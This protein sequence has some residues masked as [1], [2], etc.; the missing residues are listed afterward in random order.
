MIRYLF[1]ISL[2]KIIFI[3]YMVRILRTIIY[4]MSTVANPGIHFTRDINKIIKYNDKIN[5]FILYFYYN[6]VNTIKKQKLYHNIC[7]IKNIFI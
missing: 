7:I 2:A 3:I 5:F 4:L 6:T 1:F